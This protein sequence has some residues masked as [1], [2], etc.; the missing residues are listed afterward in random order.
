M[1]NEIQHGE[2]SGKNLSYKAY[3]PDGT[4]RTAKT[5]LPEIGSTGYY[6]ATDGNVVPGD[7]III[8]N[9]DLSDIEVGHGIYGLVAAG[10][11]SSGVSGAGYVGD[12]L[13]D[14]TVYFLWE[15][16]IAP[17]ANGTIKV[18]KNDGTV[19]V[20]IPTGIVDTRDFSDETGVHLCS[21]DL[22]VVNSFYEKAK[23]YIVVLSGATING[24]SVTAI[25]GL[26]SI[27]KRYV[28]LEFEKDH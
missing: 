21:I 13:E 19:D 8:T 3:E 15:T 23:D 25:I 4:P 11:S 18:Y 12:Y 10:V 27:E 20:G 28:G 6:T 14:R 9:D 17:T 16:T 22:G 24:K 7:F 2:V 26:F 5:A 1:A